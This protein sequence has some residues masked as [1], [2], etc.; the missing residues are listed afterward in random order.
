MRSQTSTLRA[1]VAATAV[2]MMTIAGLA[3][4]GRAEQVADAASAADAEPSSA[5]PAAPAPELVNVGGLDWH[6]DYYAAYRAAAAEK[7]FLLINVLPAGSSA[8]QQGAEQTIATNARLQQQ[9]ANVTR[10]RVPLDATIDVEGQPRRLT[11]FG[12][13]AELAGGPGWVLIDLRNKDREFYGHAVSVLPYASGK[14]YHWRPDYLSVILSIPAGTLSQR[15]MIWAVRVHPENPQS[16]YGQHNPA[17]AQGATQQASYQA[18][19]GQ[20]G[21]QNFETRFHSLSAAAGSGVSEVCAESWPGQN[22]IDSCLDCVASWRQS[23]GHWRGVSGRHRAFGYDI[24]R[25]RNGIW[26]GTGIFAD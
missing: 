14:Y 17:L 12:S 4:P 22:L 16:T 13:F 5:E 23:S 21:H 8:A 24:R 6:V 1:A 2:G 11:S 7:R 18:N 19:V 9:L 26:Y 10:L 3:P 25:G 20:Q 15:T